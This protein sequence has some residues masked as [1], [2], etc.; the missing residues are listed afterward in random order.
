MLSCGLARVGRFW[1][2]N[3][4]VFNT[5]G[6]IGLIQVEAGF[7]FLAGAVAEIFHKFSGGVAKMD[8][9]WFVAGL[10]GEVEGGIPS[11]GGGTRLFAES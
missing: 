6:Q 7:P 3:N 1:R 11:I 4:C 5:V 10:A 8:G 2:K 9:Y